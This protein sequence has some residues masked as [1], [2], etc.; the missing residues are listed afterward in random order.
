MKDKREE[1]IQ[2]YRRWLETFGWDWFGTL[3]VTSGIPSKRR[4][5]AL[6]DSWTS[7]LR[8][9]E[10]TEEFRWFRVLERGIGEDNLHYHILVGGLR[11][12]RE[13]WVQRWKELGGEA[14]I[15]PYN[16]AEKGILYL[17]KDMGSNGDLDY[18]C[19]LPPT[20]KRIVAPIKGLSR[21]STSTPTA[22]RVDR[23]D[24]ETTTTELKR[25]FKRFGRVLEIG[26]YE[27][28]NGDRTV[29]SATV[30]MDDLY[31]ALE[32]ERQLDGFE[33]RGL[34]IKVSILGRD[35]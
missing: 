32:A 7:G 18:D 6:C 34:P 22:I 31:A 1:S 4:A 26:I 3:K 5:R 11:N 16:P 28:R 33:L 29:M 19:E 35:A 15:T 14:L 24:G 13:V 21:Q 2:E 23:I 12:R 27:A 10:G 17:L 30:V 20:K 25:L 8:Q 9:A